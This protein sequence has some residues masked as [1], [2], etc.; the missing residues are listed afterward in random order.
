M[1]DYIYE[2]CSGR[3]EVLLTPKELLSFLM[4]K[5]E[6]T[7]KELDIMMGNLVLD[8][9]IESK[10]GTKDGKPYYIVCLTIKGA[11]Y[12]RERKALKMARHQSIVWKLALTVGGAVLGWV[13]LKV[14][15]LFG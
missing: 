4:P 12:D 11:A 5:I 7:A 2:K 3:G 9:Y 15:G 10:K 13:I 14:L 1:M 6:I 8:D